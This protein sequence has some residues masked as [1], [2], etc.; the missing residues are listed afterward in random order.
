MLKAVRKLPK[1][2]LSGDMLSK[3]NLQGVWFF[4]KPAQ[5]LNILM[6]NRIWNR[7]ESYWCLH[8]DLRGCDFYFTFHVQLIWHC[9]FKQCSKN[10]FSLIIEKNLNFKLIHLFQG[11][12]NLDL[13]LNAEHPKNLAG[14]PYMF[15]IPSVQMLM[16]EFLTNYQTRRRKVIILKKQC[17][18]K[19]TS[20]WRS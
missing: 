6:I 7:K 15:Q 20:I 9:A 11:N 5:L 2:Q 19:G 18:H 1:L 14:I 3:W 8:F 16:N 12:E 13:N 17:I 4:F 10:N